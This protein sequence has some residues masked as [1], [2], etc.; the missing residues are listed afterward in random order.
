MRTTRPKSIVL[1]SG[2]QPRV[3]R[4]Y[5]DWQAEQ[6]RDT[7][8]PSERGIRVGSAVLW[9]HKQ[10]GIILSDRVTVL[11]IHNNTLTVTVKDVKERT[12]DIDISEVVANDDDRMSVRE[13]N[14]P[15]DNAAKPE[16]ET[17][18]EEE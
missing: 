3:Y 4:T 9:R 15:I 11:A 1:K 16:T 6:K 7:R 18:D 2:Q 5:E 13:A 8:T 12:C 17:K 14:V 10:N